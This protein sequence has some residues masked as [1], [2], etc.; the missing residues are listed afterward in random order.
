MSATL[1][2]VRK[3]AKALG[4]TVEYDRA[5]GTNELRVTAPDGMR[6]AVELHQ[7]VDCTNAPWEPDFDDMLDRMSKG[8]EVCD[9]PECEWCHPEGE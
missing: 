5:F 6:W 9:D 2:D 7:F 1:K 8:P 3:R 4:A